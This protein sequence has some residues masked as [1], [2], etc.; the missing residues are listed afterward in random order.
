MEK[1]MS[2]DTSQEANII[3]PDA[4]DEIVAE[5][6]RERPDLNVDAKHMTGRIIRL[7]SLFQHAYV[8][9]F[10]PLGLNEGDY[11]VLVPLRR[12]GVPF[13]LSPTEL[14]EHRMMTTGGMTKALDRLESKGLVER[15]PNPADRRGSLVRLTEAGRTVVD[16][17]MNRHVVT[18][19]RLVS[20]LDEVEQ[21]QLTILLRKLLR[22]LDRG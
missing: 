19:R 11:G 12:A 14:A 20:T 17:A 21:A 18:E 2:Q 10:E 5:W 4:L 22:A 7:A 6:R 3:D 13:T 8:D 15:L 1:A 9:L 16:E